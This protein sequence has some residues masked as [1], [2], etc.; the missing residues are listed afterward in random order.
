MVP[1]K[2][3]SRGHTAFE[4]WFFLLGISTDL[5]CLDSY[6]QSETTLSTVILH[7]EDVDSNTDA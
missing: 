3:S 1:A 6:R 5:N 4:L 2:E 7:T